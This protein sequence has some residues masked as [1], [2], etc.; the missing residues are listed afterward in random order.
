MDNKT[1]KDFFKFNDADL[2]ANRL[3]GFSANQQ[4]GLEEENK[5]STRKKTGC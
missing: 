2:M 1:L 5:S 3:G 4:K